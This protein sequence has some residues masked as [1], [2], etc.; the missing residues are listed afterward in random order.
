MKSALFAT[1]LLGSVAALAIPAHATQIIA[2][3]QTSG[4]NTITATANGLGTQTTIDTNGAGAL[5]LIDQLFGAVTPPAIAGLFSLSA[6]S[7]DP[8]QTVLGAIIQHYA[9]SFCVSSAAGCTGTV[10]LK[11]TFSDA[12]FGLAGGTQ[13]SVNVASP[14]DTLAL[15]SDVIPVA[16]LVAPS[17]FTLS[18][19]NLGALSLDNATIG[20]FTASFSGV[21]N[22]TTVP[23]PA[24]LALLG[25]GLLGLGMI[26]R[27]RRVAL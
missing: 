14:P 15:S 20:S 24:S 9:G 10:D 22:A 27:R 6:T 23:E 25:T 8:A 19:S 26:A 3:G 12:A 21:A 5:V 16:D 1:T 13:L 2:F 11:G 18:L 7:I 17:S 4:S